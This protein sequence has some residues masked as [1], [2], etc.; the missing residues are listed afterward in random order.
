MEIITINGLESVASTN[1]SSTTTVQITPSVAPAQHESFFL[2]KAME[3]SYMKII[4]INGLESV[5]SINASSMTT[6]QITSSVAPAQHECFFF[7][8]F[9]RSINSRRWLFTLEKSV[10]HSSMVDVY[11]VSEK[12]RLAFIHNRNGSYCYIYK[13]EVRRLHNCRKKSILPGHLLVKGRKV[14]V[15]N[16]YCLFLF[17]ISFV[18]YISFVFSISFVSFSFYLRTTRSP[19]NTQYNDDDTMTQRA[20]T[21][22]QYVLTAMHYDVKLHRGRLLTKTSSMGQDIDATQGESSL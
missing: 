9:V 18:L 2:D 20:L 17:S 3:G 13:A 8:K 19:A 14:K 1:A 7:D 5:A 21:R 6:V 15:L 10:V 16:V 4:T 22:R 12:R 11:L